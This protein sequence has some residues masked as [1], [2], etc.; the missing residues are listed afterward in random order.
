[1]IVSSG[2]GV[3]VGHH[4]HAQVEE[5]LDVGNPAGRIAVHDGSDL[6]EIHRVVVVKVVGTA[7]V[8]VVLDDDAGSDEV[9]DVETLAHHDRHDHGVG[10]VVFAA[11]AL[12]VALLPMPPQM[13]VASVAD[14][15]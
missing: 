3:G 5:I 4:R 7:F 9:V 6:W 1:M 14:W 8:G 15:I 13:V 12:A 2:V 11:P 10:A